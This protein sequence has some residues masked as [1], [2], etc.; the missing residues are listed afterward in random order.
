[1]RVVGC[2]LEYQNKFLLLH[3]HPEKSQGD[4][5]GL[6]AGKVHE[7]ENDEEAMVRELEEETGYRASKDELV[8]LGDH[9]FEFPDLHLEFPT[10]KV[11]L[12]KPIDVKLHADEHIAF[13]WVTAEECDAMPELIRGLHDLLRR[14][15]YIKQS[16]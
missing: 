7:G 16:S 12:T 2:F 9:L 8:S 14:V 1:M 11:V 3:R 5:W 13:R 15:G 4:T 10:F 6:P